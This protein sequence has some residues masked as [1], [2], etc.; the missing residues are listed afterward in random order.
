VN[1]TVEGLINTNEPLARKRS[2]A[3]ISNLATGYFGQQG[4]SGQQDLGSG[5]P[6]GKGFSSEVI[7][8]IPEP[9]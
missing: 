4:S 2:P 9:W 8:P 7:C 5:F 6:P 1:S 3:N